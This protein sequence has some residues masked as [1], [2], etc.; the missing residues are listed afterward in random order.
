MEEIVITTENPIETAL[1]LIEEKKY[2]QLKTFWE[3]F[4]PQDIAEILVELEDR[5]DI[6]KEEL[7]IVFRL[8]PKETAADVFVEMDSDM[9]ETLIKAFSDKELEEVLDNLFLD[10]TIDIIEEMP[11]NVVRR[12]MRQ[13]SPEMRIMINKILQY[14]EDSAG[15][16][17]T[18]EYIRLHEYMTVEGAFDHIRKVGFDKE[19]IYNC[20]VV[21][22]GGKLLGLCTVKDLLLADKSCK[23]ADLMETNIISVNTQD[24]KETAAQIFSKYHFMAIPVLDREERLV[25]IIT[26]DDAMEVIQDENDEDFSKMAAITPSDT[27]YLKT[28]IWKI[29][30][31]RV[32]WLLLLMV[33][34]TF[35][36]M[37]ISKNEATLAFSITLTACIPM[38][39]GTGG[40]AGSQT[41]VTVIRGIAL[42][43]IE[44]RDIFRVFWKELRIS[45]LLGITISIACFGKLMLI[46]RLFAVQNGFSIALVICIT[47]LAT[48]VIAKLVGCILPLLAKV[49]RLDP[50]VVANPFITTIVDIL[51]LVIY[52]FITTTL[53][54]SIM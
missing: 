11:A 3:E 1:S 48:I 44:F 29:F 5:G 17:M 53:L 52:C 38:I 2:S 22:K 21:D 34:A 9:Q 39:M 27:P 20:Y 18:I 42:G 14:P 50:A 36:G 16:V 32:P 10:D 28:S 30:L 23:I 24:D 19:T 6:S 41:S 7:M 40:N 37:I 43:E 31:N 45:L 15:S 12:I 51:S 47:M 54:G 33:S 49:C 13:S 4:H 26:Y 25:G 46:D 35:T 8:L